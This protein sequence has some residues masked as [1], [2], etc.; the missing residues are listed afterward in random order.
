[1]LVHFEYDAS[2]VSD[3]DGDRGALE[4]RAE[5]G[6]HAAELLLMAAV[7][8]VVLDADQQ[9]TTGECD[10]LKLEFFEQAVGSGK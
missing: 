2:F 3:D 9:P 10:G 5:F 6:L 1:M 4:Q 8:G 7:F